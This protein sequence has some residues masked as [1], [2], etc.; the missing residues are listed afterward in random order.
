MALVRQASFRLGLL[1][2]AVQNIGT[3][4]CAGL[5]WPVATFALW[6]NTGGPGGE[7]ASEPTSNRC[8]RIV[9][10]GKGQAPCRQPSIDPPSCSRSSKPTPC[11]RWC[12]RSQATWR[13]LAGEV[14]E[15][16][17]R[18]AMLTAGRELKPGDPYADELTQIEAE[19]EA[20]IDPRSGVPGRAAGFGRR[21]QRGSG[22]PGRFSR[23][24]G[25]SHRLSLLEAGRAGS[26][27]LA[28]AGGRLC[29][30]AVADGRQSSQT[31]ASQAG[32]GAMIRSADSRSHVSAA[33][34][35]VLA[36]QQP[37]LTI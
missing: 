32:M 34:P 18:L 3:N 2:R 15:R 31:A 30:P 26:A 33:G 8:G 28:R 10:S 25:R 5:S 14:I 4:S 24:D 20:D 37:I 11:C 12:G 19:L 36:S 7:Y 1:R 27:A 22:G 6:G 16:R 21:A 23:T 13:T 35:S 29:R 17:H 9:E